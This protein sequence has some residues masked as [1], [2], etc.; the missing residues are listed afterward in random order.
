MFK[1]RASFPAVNADLPIFSLGN[2]LVAA[3]GAERTIAWLD[4]I[5]AI[6]TDWQGGDIGERGV[7]DTA[8]RGEKRRKK[9]LRDKTKDSG[10]L[11][12]DVAR[13]TTTG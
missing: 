12:L 3:P 11:S 4:G 8:I 5:K 6:V 1:T 7:T 13:A 2:Q 10:E 9:A